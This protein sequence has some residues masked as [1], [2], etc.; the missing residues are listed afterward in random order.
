MKQKV[1]VIGAGRWGKNIIKTFAGMGSL[2][3]VCEQDPA[4]R[5]TIQDTYP[6]AL[7]FEKMEDMLQQVGGPSQL[8]LR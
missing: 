4:L 2:A 6:E 8:Q 3:S 5:K 7:V 1:S